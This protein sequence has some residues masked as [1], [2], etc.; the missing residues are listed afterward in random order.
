MQIVDKLSWCQSEQS[1]GLDRQQLDRDQASW[2]EHFYVWNPNPGVHLTVDDYHCLS[3][4]NNRE[5]KML[6]IW[7]HTRST[8]SL[9]NI[10]FPSAKFWSGKGSN[11]LNGANQDGTLIVIGPY[12]KPGQERCLFP[13]IANLGPVFDYRS[14]LEKIRSKSHQRLKGSQTSRLNP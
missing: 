6:S 5:D 1:W 9:V 14:P 11:T 8:P 3:N 7:Q 10:Q 4:M 13:S 12:Q 2:F